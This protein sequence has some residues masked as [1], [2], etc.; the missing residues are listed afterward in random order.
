[1]E[2]ENKR[3]KKDLMDLLENQLQFN[4]ESSTKIGDNNIGQIQSGID[5]I[6]NLENQLVLT[7]TV[8]YSH[9]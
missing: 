5:A 7:K 8:I 9:I 4:D 6:A 1:M 2:D 3:L